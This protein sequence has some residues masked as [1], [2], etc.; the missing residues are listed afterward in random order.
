ML[1][2]EALAERLPA[3]VIYRSP[4]LPLAAVVERSDWVERWD[5]G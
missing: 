3:S 4:L 1:S 2:P 5:G